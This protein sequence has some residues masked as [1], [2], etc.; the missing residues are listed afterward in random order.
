MRYN[1]VSHFFAVKL[2]NYENCHLF[3]VI[4]LA[5]FQ[6]DMVFIFEDNTFL[7]QQT[8][9]FRPVGSGAAGMIDNSVAGES[10]V[11]FSPGNDFRHQTGIFISA[12]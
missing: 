8:A 5:L 12:D 6:I 1:I 2:Y 10:A 11:I 3:S 4:P 9:L 7:F